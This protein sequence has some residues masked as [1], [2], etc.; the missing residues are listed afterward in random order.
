[1]TLDRTR[2]RLA[3]LL[4]GLPMLLA[5]VYFTLL[6]RDRYVSTAVL[7]VRHTGQDRPALGGLS[8]LLSGTAGASLEDTRYLREYLHSLGLLQALDRRLKIRSH[9]ESARSDVLM[10]LETGTSQEELLDYWRQ[11]VQVSLD[12]TSGL[13]T[14]RVQGFDPAFAQQVNQA[15]LAESEAFINDISRRIANEQLAFSRTE[16]TRAGDLL[17]QTQQS[18]IEF[19]ARHQ[20][21]DPLAETQATGARASELRSRASRLEAELHAKQAFLNDDAPDIVTLK[22]ELSAVRQQIGHET[23]SATLGAT[24]G[25][26]NAQRTLNKLAVE[27]HGLKT[28]VTLAEGAYKSALASVE[29]TRIESSRKLKSLVVIEPPTHPEM[30]EFPRRLY[31]LATLL[32]ACLIVFATVQLALATVQ[33]HRD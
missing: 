1:M 30:A 14:L 25:K 13:L 26:S 28:Q 3:L 20:M 23:S 5:A 9:F 29:A 19:Q 22:A 10:R 15:L 27:F 8:T 4:I 24:S 6:S 16:L 31:D 11:R 7:T 17:A 18:L 12:E 2:Q 33:E 32:M 21:L